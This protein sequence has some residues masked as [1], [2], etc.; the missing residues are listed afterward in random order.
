MDRGTRRSVKGP[1]FLI[2]LGLLVHFAPAGCSDSSGGRSGGQGGPV[3]HTFEYSTYL[4]GSFFDRAQGVFVDDQGFIYLGGNTNSADYPTTALAFDTSKNGPSGNVNDAGDGF[5]AKFAPTGA[6]IWSTFLGGTRRDQVYGVRADS[7]GYVYAV[8]STGSDDLL[9]EAPPSVTGFD[10]TF[11]GP[12]QTNGYGDIFV[13]KL[14]P[15]GGSVVYWTYVGGTAADKSRGSMH[16]NA[17][18]SL[19]VSGVS[20]S[21]DFPIPPAMTP[22]PYQGSRAAGEEI[23]VFRL[24]A[25]GMGIEKAT[26]LG[27]SGSE[28]GLS[29]VFATSTGDVIVAGGTSSA[30]FPGTAPGSYG[31]G[32]GGSWSGGDGYV[33][34]LSGDLSQLRYSLYIGGP[35]DDYGIH[36]QGL[37]VDAQ[38]RAILLVYTN[39]PNLMTTTGSG[40]QGARDAYIAV[41][42]ADGSQVE[43][44]TYVGG[45]GDD[46]PAGITVDDASGR[47]YFTGQTRSADYPC[48]PNALGSTL[49]GAVDVMVTAL[50]PDLS[51]AYSTILEGIPTETEDQRGRG[52]WIGPGGSYFAS[53]IVTA[54]FPLTANA[55]QSTAGGR[56][57]GFVVRFTPN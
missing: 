47:I 2:L 18:G 55:W 3:D 24:S 36:N 28:A 22:P 27:G 35:N 25:D 16:L 40:F 10:Q 44:A 15:D 8:G 20:Q 9:F 51:L 30:D 52:G 34:C 56:G 43:A 38:D 7:Q 13:V 33:A 11:N 21:D 23:V 37:A 26:L 12:T 46:Y 53:G 48:T 39:S 1:S 6:L 4:G 50:G 54:D 57:D 5:V 31:G 41:V 17:D 45:S 14:S 49:G 29:G 32:S 19:Y 42:A